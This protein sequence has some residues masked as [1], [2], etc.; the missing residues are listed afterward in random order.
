MK[1]YSV[2]TMVRQFKGCKDVEFV[3]FRCEKSDRQHLYA[4]LVEN[5]VGDYYVEDY[6]ESLFT[7]DEARQ[8]KTWLDLNRGGATTIAEVKVP[9]PHN[10]MGVGAIAVGGGQDFLVL[11]DCSLPF[12]VMA[13][14]DLR[15]RERFD[16]FGLYYG[17]HFIGGS[18]QD[19]PPPDG[20]AKSSESA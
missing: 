1:L 9:V 19:N 4:D 17:Y 11:R 8:L 13:Y 6:I 20:H 15:Y 18:K 16:G 14:Y 10:A 2:V 5:H 7:E 3:W 12:K